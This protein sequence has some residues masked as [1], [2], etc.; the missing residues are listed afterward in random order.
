MC[1]IQNFKAVAMGMVTAIALFW[2][3]KPNPAIYRAFYSGFHLDPELASRDEGAP[4]EGRTRGA[5]GGGGR[6][7]YIR[8]CSYRLSSPQAAT[9]HEPFSEFK[10]L[11]L[12]GVVAISGP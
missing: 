1:L 3:N 10:M 9:S 5:A 2:S 11:V 8:S 7:Y 4:R 12:A 6:S